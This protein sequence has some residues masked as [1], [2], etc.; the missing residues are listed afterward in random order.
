M[1]P[2]Y[3]Y[4]KRHSVTG[5]CYFGKTI[6]DPITYFGSGHHWIRHIKKHGKEYVETLWYKLFTDQTEL[7]RIATLFSEQQDIVKSD[8][9]LNLKTEN[10]LDG[11]WDDYNNNIGWKGKT[12]SEEHKRKRLSQLVGIKRPNSVCK[13][14]SETRLRKSSQGILRTVGG[15]PKTEEHKAKLRIPKIKIFCPICKKM[16]GGQTNFNRWHGDN[17]KPRSRSIL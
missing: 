7:V 17:C 9:W 3:L 10:G 14:I 1:K 4:I 16:V 8:L 11:G 15:I 2:T 6:T 13:K 12:Q 5:K